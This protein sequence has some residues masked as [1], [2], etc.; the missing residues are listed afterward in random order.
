[1]A[2]TPEKRLRRFVVITVIILAAIVL[3]LWASIVALEPGPEGRIVMATG[4]AGGLYHEL[5]EIYKKDLRRYGVELDLRPQVEGVNTFKGLMPKYR[6]DFKTYDDA[7]ADIQA[8]FLKGGYSGSMQGSLASERAQIWRERQVASLR[9]VGRLFHEPIWVFHKGPAPL[10]S[11]RDLKSRK[12]YVGTKVSGSRRVVMQMLKANNVTDRNAS[13]I[14]EDLP[15]DAGPLIRGEADAALMILPPE[16]PKIQT[17]LRNQRISLMS[18]AEEA[19]A[20][21]SRFPALSKVTLRQGAAA[22]D[23]PIPADDV[24]LLTTSVAL[25]VRKTLSPSLVTLLTHAVM[26]NPKSG[27]DK[28]GDP[29]LFYQ[30]GQFPSA[31]DPEFELAPEARQ[32][33]KS[34]ELPMVLKGMTLALNRLHLPFW[35]AVFANE[36]G[37]Q[38]VLI[39]IPI[40]SVIWPLMKLIPMF[41]TWTMRRRLLYWYRQLKTLEQSID[42]RPSLDHLEFKRAQLE[43]IDLAVSRLQV[44][45]NMSDQLYDLRSHIDLVRQRLTAGPRPFRAPAA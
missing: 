14:D 38:T 28:E 24:V 35:P 9:S 13:F 20:Y 36:R 4:G 29:I 3:S 27:F 33:Y 18:F 25:V 37:I 43:R 22:F 31:N 34:G 32:L 12:L 44:P 15:D 8:G 6:S 41:Y 2:A 40:L 16:S 17:L 10:R 7:N 45:L 5:A 26:H 23:P 30:P 1:M 19:D 11:L 39:A 42:R 21:A